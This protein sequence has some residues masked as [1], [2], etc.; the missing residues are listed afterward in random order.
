MLL[1]H[2]RCDFHR[3]TQ[4]FFGNRVT[5]GHHTIPG[6]RSVGELDLGHLDP[7]LW[8]DQRPSFGCSHEAERV[9][10]SKAVLVA[11]NS[12][13]GGLLPVWVVRVELYGSVHAEMLD[14]TPCKLWPNVTISK[15]S[16][17]SIRYPYLASNARANTPTASGAAAEVPPWPLVHL[18]LPTSVVC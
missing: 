9:E 5:A 10:S 2:C 15:G 14:I 3:A 11:I 1:Q 18:R 6:H 16:F 7:R 17:Y 13:L 12:A 4:S 8:F